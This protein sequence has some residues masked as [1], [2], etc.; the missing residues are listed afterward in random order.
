MYI[1]YTNLTD[2]EPLN[3]ATSLDPSPL[4]P[5]HKLA[6]PEK[7]TVEIFCELPKGLPTPNLWWEGPD[8]RL[9]PETSSPQ[10]L[11]SYTFSSAKL[12]QP[13]TLLVSN[14]RAD[15]TGNYACVAENIAG[16]TRATVQL[17]VVTSK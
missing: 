5:S 15:Q 8:G 14:V 6:V 3:S 1:F 11:S 16:K 9:I 17:V 10:S 12:R 4:I 13:N 2:I 7:G